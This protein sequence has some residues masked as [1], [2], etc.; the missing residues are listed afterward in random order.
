YDHPTIS[1]DPLQNALDLLAMVPDDLRLSVDLVAHSRG[2]LVARSLVELTDA[3]QKF[4][5]RVLVTHGTPHSGTRLADPDRWD[6]LISLGMT[7]ASWLAA[8]A[9]VTAWI[10]KL[11]EYVL[12]AAAQGIFALPGIAA[13]TP[14]GDFI[15]HLNE[16]GAT[17]ERARYAAV[18]SSFSI[19]NVPQP[20]FRQAF[21]ALAVQ[22][23]MDAPNDLVVPTASM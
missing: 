3:V 8:I 19:F 22:A 11:L 14:G 4:D 2:G 5:P 1:R 17:A 13:M 23:F 7:A 9:G 16:I 21:E 10:P 6:R 18:S 12:K 15:N 20:S